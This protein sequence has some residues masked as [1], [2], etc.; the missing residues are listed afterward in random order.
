[1]RCTGRPALGVGRNQIKGAVRRVRPTNRFFIRL[2][3]PPPVASLAVYALAP[4]RL[5]RQKRNAIALLA[6]MLG[7][8]PIARQ[9]NRYTPLSVNNRV[10]QKMAPFY[11]G[12]WGRG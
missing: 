11:H 1:M 2:F 6:P 4:D 9:G 5:A 8:L 12:F 10:G 3:L 7:V